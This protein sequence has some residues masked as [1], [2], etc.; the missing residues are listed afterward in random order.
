VEQADLIWHNGELVAWEDAKVHVLTHGLH[1]GTGVFEGIRAYETPTGTSVFRHREHLE[2][3]FKSAELYY[4]PIPYTLEELRAATHEL[5]LANELRE[6][7]IRPIAFRGYG[8]MGLY[9]LDSPVEVSIAAWPWGAY[10]GDE[11]KLSG[12]RAKVASWR[13][14]SHDSLIPHAK[15]SGQYL[16]SVLAKIEASKAG[17]QEAILLDHRGFVCEGSGENIYAV[18]DGQIVTPPHAAGILDGISRKSIVQIAQDLG[19]ELVERD[20]ARAELY[21]ADEVFLSGTAAELVPVREIDDHQIG[22][23]K[24]GP[25]TLELQRVFDDALHGRDPRYAAWLDMVKVPSSQTA[26]TTGSP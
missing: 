8:Q 2:R 26:G 12:I 18:R 24:P 9:P 15:A 6:C 16:N 4:M 17:Y 19:Y 14:I 11:S 23:G 21:L 10:L 22:E 5:I 1:Y 7:Y 3:L 25:I 20:I 13:R